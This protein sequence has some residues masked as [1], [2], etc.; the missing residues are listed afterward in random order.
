MVAIVLLPGMDGTGD[1]FA[2]FIAALGPQH[3]VTVVRYPAN[4]ALGYAELES[5]A[6]AALP[7]DG[8]FVLLGE[9]FSGPVA[10]S[11]AASR[12][13][14][15][16]GLVLCC[17]F[18]RNPRPAFSILRSLVGVLPVAAAPKGLLGWLLLGRF[19]TAALRAAFARALL[20]VSPA[21]LRARV[22]A[23][24]CVDV[25]AQLAEADVPVLYLRASRDRVVPAAASRLV[26]QLNPSTRV[27]Q[28]EA[29]HFLLQAAPAEA[30]QAVRAFMRDVEA[31]EP[32]GAAHQCDGA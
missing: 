3:K 7:S 26:A 17:T 15:L 4:Q 10:I 8:P 19:S 13:P 14:Q 28:L 2:P 5:I 11:L 32:A 16:K 30:A 25:S 21:A 27:V 31:L 20:Q 29:P 9:S 6:R 12:P 23:V 18:A 22:R 24:L 1:L